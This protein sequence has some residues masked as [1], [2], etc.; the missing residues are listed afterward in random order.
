MNISERIEIDWGWGSFWKVL[1]D[2][3]IRRVGERK[4]VGCSLLD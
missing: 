4:R 1:E 3:R 2:E